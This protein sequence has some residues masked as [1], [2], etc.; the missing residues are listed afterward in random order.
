MFK[1][2]PED[3][4]KII[5]A[6]GGALAAVGGTIFGICKLVKRKKNKDT[7]EDACCCGEECTCQE[8]GCEEDCCCGDE[9]EITVIEYTAEIVEDEAVEEVAVAE[10]IEKE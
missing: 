5:L 10:E 6:I 8:E 9:D 7:C 1:K 4:F 3:S 2:K